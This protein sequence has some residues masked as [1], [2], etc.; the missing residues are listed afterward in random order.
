MFKGHI[1]NRL[2]V[3]ALGVAVV[4]GGTVAGAHPQNSRVDKGKIGLFKGNNFDLDYYDAKGARPSISL[5]F[6]VA[7]IAVFPGEKWQVC[8]K[9]RFQ[10]PC[11]TI[12]KDTQNLGG[13]PVLSARPIKDAAP[14]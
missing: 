8:A 9:P 3:A 14:K 2:I 12:D 5:D 11:M 6:D 1:M 7:S 4:A 10:E 13:V